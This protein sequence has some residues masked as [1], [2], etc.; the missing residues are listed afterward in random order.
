LLRQL[1][2][3]SETLEFASIDLGG[4]RAAVRDRLRREGRLVVAISGGVDS[5][6]LLA[7]S[8]EA[9]GAARVTAVT[10]HSAAVPVEELEDARLVAERLG[11]R[12]R[13]VETREIERVDYRANRGDRC[14]HCRTELF[15]LLAD[16]AAA[17]GGARI[18]Y[19]AILDDLGD[20]RPGMRAAQ[21]HG[22]LA[23]LLDAGIN[24]EDVRRLA[25]AFALP[26]ALKPAAPCLAS[27]IPTGTEVTHERLRQVEA[28][29]RGLKALGFR[30][31]RVRHHGELAR[32]EVGRDER[33]R[34]AEPETLERATAAVRAAGF[35]HVTLDPAGLRS[36]RAAPGPLYSIGPAR[37]SG[38]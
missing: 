8:V 14:F 28:A 13:V 11:V 3:R 34:F 36:E 38:Q 27:R 2:D 24:K 17:E 6:V 30:E 32:I 4:K 35:R 37:P 10:G 20:D 19:G 22:V 23:P 1:A 26:V 7:L 21:E 9:L 29:E 15:E 12:W 31:L 16:L 33:A 5:A 25:A 18:A